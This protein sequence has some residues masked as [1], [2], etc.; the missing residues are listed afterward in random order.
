ML[1]YFR[2]IFLNLI[3]ENFLSSMN[4][5][6]S[7]DYSMMIGPES[8]DT[9]QVTED[10]NQTST[11]PCHNDIVE[12]VM[13]TSESAYD[14]TIPQ[15]DRTSDGVHRRCPT[16]STPHVGSESSTPADHIS[17]RVKFMETERTMSVNKTITVG[18]LKR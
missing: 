14:S 8:A 6:F 10:L 4:N 13:S 15:M 7:I 17:I 1:L 3:L 18:E 9:G 16:Q 5:I 11:G 2:D 12:E